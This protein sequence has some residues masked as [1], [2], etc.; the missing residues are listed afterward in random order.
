MSYVLHGVCWNKGYFVCFCIKYDR[1]C[2]LTQ[3]AEA[4]GS[5]ENAA[6][7]NLGDYFIVVRS[8]T[9]LLQLVSFMACFYLRK[10]RSFA[11]LF[12]PSTWDICSENAAVPCYKKLSWVLLLLHLPYPSW[13][14]EG[15]LLQSFILS[16]KNAEV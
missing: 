2:F 8:Q 3:K 12:L 15:V 10:H 9:R 4:V 11:F 6:T 5:A 1:A 7:K 13:K 14:F 16:Q